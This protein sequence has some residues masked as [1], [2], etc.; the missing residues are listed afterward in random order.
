M[1]SKSR[2]LLD[3]RQKLLK[4]PSASATHTY[5]STCSLRRGGHKLHDAAMKEDH[6]CV[7]IDHSRGTSSN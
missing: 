2:D 4:L 5:P 3:D 7:N 6:L 1:E